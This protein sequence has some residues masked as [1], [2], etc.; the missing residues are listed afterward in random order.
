MA[1]SIKSIDMDRI[2]T[3]TVNLSIG[4]LQLFFVFQI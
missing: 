4:E 3:K 2:N 1:C